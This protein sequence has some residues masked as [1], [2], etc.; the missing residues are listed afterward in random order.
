MTQEKKRLGFCSPPV[1]GL[2][3]A[4][5]CT[6]L[7][8]FGQSALAD[9]ADMQAASQPVPDYRAF[10]SLLGM[11]YAGESRG[12]GTDEHMRYHLVAEAI[13]AEPTQ[14]GA[15]R[16]RAV[17]ARLRQVYAGAE[18]ARDRQRM[19]LYCQDGLATAPYRTLVQTSDQMDVENSIIDQQQF[20]D[21]L[22]TL[23]RGERANMRVYLERNKS[24][25]SH[26]RVSIDEVLQHRHPDMSE[27]DRAEWL[28][29]SLAKRCAAAQRRRAE[30]QSK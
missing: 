14:A 28:R 4:L 9:D 13:G 17:D 19:A 27:T 3:C 1:R 29:A 15:A 21:G 8:L 6:G 23:K 22:A 24:G 20:Q 5:A 2:V 30:G 16:M 25:I 12:K 11:L 7:V 26:A 10:N 18:R